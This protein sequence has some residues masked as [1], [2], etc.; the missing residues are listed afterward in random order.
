MILVD[1]SVWITHL[2]DGVGR[3]A[4]LLEDGQVLGHPWVAG[5]LALGT[6]AQ[7]HVVLE[8][9][10]NL[11]QATTASDPEVMTLIE[12]RQLFGRGIGFVDAHLLAATM[13]TDG[14]R[15]WTADQRLA[16]AAADL[17]VAP[18]G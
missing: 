16:A 2:R 18:H 13:L 9:L 5:E 7:R 17:G 3:L 11:P 4:L 8:L 6:L 15:L 14:S 12:T 1:T 10:A